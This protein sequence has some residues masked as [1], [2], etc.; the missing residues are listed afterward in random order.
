V[1]RLQLL[2]RLLVVGDEL[3]LRRDDRKVGETP[4]LQLLVVLLGRRQADQVPD[5]PRDDVVVANEMGL[6]LALFESARKRAREVAADGR[7]LGDDERLANEFRV[8]KG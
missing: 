6:V 7:L 4:L 3:E 8:A 5:R 1:D 2:L